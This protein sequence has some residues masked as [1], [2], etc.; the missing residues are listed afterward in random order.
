[1]FFGKFFIVI[2]V[3]GNMVKNLIM[4]MGYNGSLMLFRVFFLE[5][6]GYLVDI[7][8]DQFG[9]GIYGYVVVFDIVFCILFFLRFGEYIFQVLVDFICYGGYFG[10]EVLENFIVFFNYDNNIIVFVFVI[11]MAI[12]IGLDFVFGIFFDSFW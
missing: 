9:S 11:V 2:N 12:C 10:N 6:E 4:D 1:M 3:G 7:F 8:I 5:F